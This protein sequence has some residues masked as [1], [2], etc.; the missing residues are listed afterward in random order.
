MYSQIK[1]IKAVQ[2]PNV[3]GILAIKLRGAY[4]NHWKCYAL[5]RLI[6]RWVYLNGYPFYVKCATVSSLVSPTKRKA[7]RRRRLISLGEYSKNK[8]LVAYKLVD[9]ESVV[10]PVPLVYPVGGRG[11]LESPH[12][13]YKF[14]E[15]SV[16]VVE[17][18]MLYGGS[19]LVLVDEMVVCHDL[20]DVARDYT[21]E[22][23]HGKILVDPKSK[24]IRWLMHDDEPVKLP[25]AATFVDACAPNYAHWLTEVLPRVALFCDDERYK[26][27]PIVINDDL[28]HNILDSL[29]KLTGLERDI[30]ALPVGRGL[31]VD[32]LCITSVAGYVPFER[33][34]NKILGHSHGIFSAHGFNML[35]RRLGNYDNQIKGQRW[36]EKIFI[37]RNSGVRKVIN[38]REIEKRLV[39]EG[40]VIIEPEKLTFSMQVELFR[41]AKMVV[42]SSGAALANMI[43]LPSDAQIFILIGKHPD[44][45]YWYWQNMA[46]ASGNVVKYVFGVSDNKGDG[47][48]SDFVIDV[49]EL[50]LSLDYKE[51]M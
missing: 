38:R 37:R 6:V 42:G 44:T 18:A 17:N 36:P 13:R 50:M 51:K 34:T 10:T 45:S 47:I 27:V 3:G 23:L 1:K 48:H 46:C 4:R 30:F 49:D 39:A 29:I 7:G 8:G 31:I 19:N 28:H 5:V 11:C 41:N 35:A 24:H 33:R 43:F 25:I 12:D 22:E 20:F 2:K 21:S 16:T 15:I 40:Y 14:P 32:T 26:D 9:A